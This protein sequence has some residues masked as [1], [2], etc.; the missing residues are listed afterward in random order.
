MRSG[1]ANVNEGKSLTVNFRL[2]A[3]DHRGECNK[4]CPELR[5]LKLGNAAGTSES[6]CKWRQVMELNI[7]LGHPIAAI[8]FSP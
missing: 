4:W 5:T 6:T 2:T 3:W 1:T 7:Y 8:F